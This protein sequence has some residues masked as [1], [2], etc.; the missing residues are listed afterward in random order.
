ML[1][2]S[3]SAI[4][5]SLW[6]VLLALHLERPQAKSIRPIMDPSKNNKMSG[7]LDLPHQQHTYKLHQETV[8]TIEI[9]IIN[10][11]ISHKET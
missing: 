8:G 10:G 3:K 4:Q 11:E 5:S 7:Y 9:Q 1:A 6:L 2:I